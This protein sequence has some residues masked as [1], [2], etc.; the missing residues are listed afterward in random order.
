MASVTGVAVGLTSPVVRQFLQVCYWP[1]FGSY[2]PADSIWSRE[3]PMWFL[4]AA[5]ADVALWPDDDG[6]PTAGPAWPVRAPKFGSDGMPWLEFVVMRVDPTAECAEAMRR[7]PGV[8][9]PWWS[10]ESPLPIE[11]LLVRG[12]WV[13]LRPGSR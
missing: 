4:P 12:G 5:G 1:E 7:I 11:D 9:K 10:A 6:D 3:V 2:G 8:E 13:Q